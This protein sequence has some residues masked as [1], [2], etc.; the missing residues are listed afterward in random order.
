MV[1]VGQA[2]IVLQPGEQAVDAFAGAGNG[3]VDALFGEQQGALDVVVEQGLQQGFA[4]REVVRQGDELV[5]RRDDDVLG[6]AG[7]FLPVVAHAKGGPVMKTPAKAGAIGIVPKLE[8]N[9]GRKTAKRFPADW[10]MRKDVIHPTS[11]LNGRACCHPDRS[12]N[13]APSPATPIP[14]GYRCAGPGHGTAPSVRRGWR[15]PSGAA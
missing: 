13:P 11:A 15:R 6:H 10:W 2:R 12:A 3:A 7:Y 14:R 4:Q 5:Q 8:A 1:D 9:A